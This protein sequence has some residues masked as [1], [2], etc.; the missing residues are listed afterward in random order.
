MVFCYFAHQAGQMAISTC[1]FC[2]FD[3]QTEPVAGCLHNKLRYLSG[4]NIKILRKLSRNI[5]QK[6]RMFIRNVILFYFPPL[7]KNG[8]AI[9]GSA[10]M[11]IVALIGR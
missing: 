6:L 8:M 3:S 9:S 4:T 10:R 5:P 7:R 11:A 2:Y 1:L